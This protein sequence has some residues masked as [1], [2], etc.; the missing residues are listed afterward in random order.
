MHVAVLTYSLGPGIGTLCA[1]GFCVSLGNDGLHKVRA[2]RVAIDAL[3][4]TELEEHTGRYP[5]R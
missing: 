2:D 5:G 1:D 4:V 3:P